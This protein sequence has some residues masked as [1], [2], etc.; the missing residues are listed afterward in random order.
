[1]DPP[2]SGSDSQPCR[3]VEGN[4][5]D[6]GKGRERRGGESY[7]TYISDDRLSVEGSLGLDGVGGSRSVPVVGRETG[8]HFLS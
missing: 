1:M 3:V 5:P 4:G 8:N 7:H 6:N 2:D